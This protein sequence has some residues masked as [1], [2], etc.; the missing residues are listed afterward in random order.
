MPPRRQIPGILMYIPGDS[1][2][3]RDSDTK[4]GQLDAC[5]REFRCAFHGVLM[6]MLGHS[7]VL[8]GDSDTHLWLFYCSL[9]G[10]LMHT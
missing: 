5:A 2:R 7:N 6:H 9:Q 10:I 1:D 4:T 8:L 3:A